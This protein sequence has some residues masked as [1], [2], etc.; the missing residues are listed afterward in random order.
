MERKPKITKIPFCL[1]YLYKKKMIK[2]NVITIKNKLM[3]T[4][5]KFPSPSLKN[6]KILHNIHLKFQYDFQKVTKYFSLLV[7]FFQKICVH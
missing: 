7:I 5:E 4:G 6:F 3:N 1:K 2:F